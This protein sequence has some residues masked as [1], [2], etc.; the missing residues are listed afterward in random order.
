MVQRQVA[1]GERNLLTD[2]GDL[3]LP[4]KRV[5]RRLVTSKA[6]LVLSETARL[7]AAILMELKQTQSLAPYLTIKKS[8]GEANREILEK[9]VEIEVAAKV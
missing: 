7:K 4:P 6:Q 1:S 5:P 9:I 8:P 2:P 3:E